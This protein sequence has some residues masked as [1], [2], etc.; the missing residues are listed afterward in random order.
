[1]NQQGAVSK[2]R[3]VMTPLT[4]PERTRLIAYLVIIAVMG[5]FLCAFI[6]V[7]GS[8]PDPGTTALFVL[9]GIIGFNYRVLLP[10]NAKLHATWPLLVAALYCHGLPLAM[11]T[12]VTGMLCQFLF[13]RNALLNSLFNSGQLALSLG[14]AGLTTKL[15]SGLIPEGIL[16]YDIAGL[17]LGMAVFDVCNIALVSTA[18]AMNEQLPWPDCFTDLFFK[19][20]R[21]ILPLLY[22]ITLAG[23]L[24]CSFI[25]TTGLV[26]IFAH[27][28]AVWHLMRFQQELNTKIE[29]ART[30]HLTGAFNYRYLEDWL[31]NEFRDIVRRGLPCSFMFADVDGLKNINDT[32]GHDAGDA[33][34]QH[35]TKVLFSITKQADVVIRYGGDEF[36]VIGPERDVQSAT[37][38]ASQFIQLLEK[39]FDY[40]GNPVKVDLSMG[41]ACYPEDGNIG[42]DLIRL[43][44]WAMYHAKKSQGNTVCRARDIAS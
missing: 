8:L 38:T 28:F 23:A 33:V 41:I 36:V 30:D 44:D 5:I 4:G 10:S 18:I 13:G 11:L 21:S 37:E 20:R 17:V 39:P 34:L 42:R 19:E 2:N 14:L 29:E 7:E 22:L 12:G 35:L 16:I 40:K 6:L 31:H 24:L 32:Y 9:S 1:M 3:W 25:G 26:I 15:V 43:A 27:V